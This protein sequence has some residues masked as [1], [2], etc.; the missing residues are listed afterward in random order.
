MGVMRP[1]AGDGDVDAHAGA[2]RGGVAVGGS[3]RARAS[4]NFFFR[5]EALFRKKGVTKRD[6]DDGRRGDRARRAGA[7]R[8]TPA[9]DATS[10]LRSSL[11]VEAGMDTAS[12]RVYMIFGPFLALQRRD[13]IL[14]KGSDSRGSNRDRLA[15]IDYG[16]MFGLGIARG[17]AGGSTL[18]IEARLEFSRASRP[19]DSGPECSRSS[20]AT[21]LLGYSF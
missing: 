17:R 8:A 20:S 15:D 1:L 18:L 10:D 13:R 12:D 19:A 21:V 5:L 9:S 3:L 6:L 16:G 11:L 4:D 7:H 14:A 2:A